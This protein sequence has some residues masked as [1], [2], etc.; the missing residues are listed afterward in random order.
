MDKTKQ[1]YFSLASTLALIFVFLGYVVK[2]YPTWLFFDAPLQNFIRGDLPNEVTTFFKWITQFA[3]PVP[4]SILTGAVLLLLLSQKEKIAALWLFLNMILAGGVLNYLMKLVYSRQR[5][6]LEHLVTENSFSFPSG[7]AMSSMLFFGTIIFL[8]FQM[9]NKNLRYLLQG[10]G[11]LC[12][13]L[14]GLSRIYL[15]VHYVSDI[16]GG[17]LLGATWLLAT[18]PYY[19]KYAFIERFKDPLKRGRKK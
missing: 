2:F 10:L 15:G 11:V 18:Y 17:W 8:L 1:K 3:N 4:I 9:K 16:L 13:I 14:I 5:P 6:S 7:H 12:L 19:Q